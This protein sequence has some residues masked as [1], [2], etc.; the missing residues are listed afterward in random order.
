MWI[1]YK[2][3]ILQQRKNIF[4]TIENFQND[5]RLLV[6]FIRD[7]VTGN[8]EDRVVYLVVDLCDRMIIGHD[9]SVCSSFV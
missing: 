9:G 4:S 1:V 7:T 2:A 3:L 6:R 8:F 5:F